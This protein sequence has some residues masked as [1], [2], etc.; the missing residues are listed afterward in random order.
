V[1]AFDALVRQRRTVYLVVALLFTAGVGAA[2]RLPA[3]I[4]PELKFP[5]I[6]VVAQGTAL[7]PREMVF[8]VTRPLEEAAGTV[9]GVERVRSR[10]I[11]GA[12][13]LSIL[14]AP[15]T[16]MLTALQLL[17][18]RIAEVRSELPADVEIIAERMLPS[19]F[20]IITYNVTGADPAQLYDVAR[21]EIKPALSRIR[22]VGRIEVQGADVREIEV[23]AEPARLAAAGLTFADLADALRRSLDVMA[24]G[25]VEANY[26]QLLVITDNDA[27]SAEEVAALVL[28]GGARVGEIARVSAGTEDR[29]RLISGDGVPAVLINVSRQPDGNTLEV[30]SAVAGEL[31]ALQPSL[32]PGVNVKAVY[33]QADLVR[34]GVH[35]VRDA[36]LIGAALVIIVLL[37]FLREPRITLISA[38]T[39]PLALALTVFVMRLMGQTFNLMSL[40]GMAIAVG[41]VIDDAVVVTENIARHLRRTAVRH[42]AIRDAL[43]EL[44]WPVTTSTLTTV[45]VFL[46]LGLLQGVV[47]Q[48]FLALSITLV[49]AV[50]ISLALALTVVPLLCD[51]LLATPPAPAAGEA[52][53]AGGRLVRGGA[54]LASAYA[55]T[56]D[57]VLRRPRLILPAVLLLILAGVAVSRFVATG[58]LPV[59][60]E[61]AFV[62]DYWTPGG[63]ALGETDRELRI[64]E[65]ILN[66]TPEIAGMSRRTGA[67]MGLFATQQN[68]GDIVVRLAPRAQRSRH[69]LEVID[70][71][72]AR[73]ETAVPRM[74]VEFI[75]LLSDLINDLAGVPDPLEIKLFGDDLDVLEGYGR[76]IAP[77]LEEVPGLVDLYDGVTEHDF[78][79]RMRVDEAAAARAGLTPGD[80]S[81]QVAAALLGAPA[82][83][84]RTGERAIGV[85]VRAPDAVRFDPA[86]LGALPLATSGHERM[87]LSAAVTLR[88]AESRSELLRE[89]Q[90]PMIVVTAGVEERSL[91]RVMADVRSVLAAHPAPAGVRVELGGQ[92]ASQQAAFLSLMLVLGLA[93][94]CVVAVLLVQFESFVE[95]LIILLVAPLS[96]VG[97]GALLLLT[98]IPLNVSSLMGMILLVGL[99][100]KNGILLLDFARHRMRFDNE[101]LG[102]AMRAA[103]ATRL[104]PI[105]MTT[106]ATLVGLL[107]LALG[108]GAGAEQQRPLALAVLGGLALSTPITLLIVP[109]LT[110]LVRGGNYTLQRRKT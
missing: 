103:A 74:R 85:R 16:D 34:E 52:P 109:A 76:E 99:V 21:Y 46:P 66:Q 71:A 6:T 42:E 45:V 73:I 23:V 84:V 90:R 95:P 25:R 72:R 47:G 26:K 4:Y 2:L 3:A 37:L 20:P 60:D 12:A 36:M 69:I 102:Q 88:P 87:P 48:F 97:G 33:D 89:N 27:H 43:R 10:T 94:L 75:Q 86:R 49:T 105:L 104:R 82:G 63:T 107:P 41:L 51:D 19:V 55:R 91:S 56:L 8:G 58:F 67:E 106:L 30:A 61:G 68:T 50:L 57:R 101:P 39:I 92:F 108:V 15:R 17:Q 98:G 54:R 14:F 24:I 31:R 80:I 64:V 100:V 18:S 40:G 59:M 7:G 78:E 22:G 81:A 28:P 5:L 53:A 11:R 32:P 93:A 65:R 70:D 96:F 83:M 38:L 13:E 44:V 77:D 29:V 62:L 35:S 1:S 110:V 79:L 9:P